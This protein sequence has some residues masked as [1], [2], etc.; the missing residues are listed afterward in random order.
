MVTHRK[1]A[2]AATTILMFVAGLVTLTAGP[3]HAKTCSVTPK[4]GMGS[5]SI[6]GDR[7]TEGRAD[8]AL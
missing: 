5:I 3:A 2:T 7:T 8:G 6:R 1:A 4:A